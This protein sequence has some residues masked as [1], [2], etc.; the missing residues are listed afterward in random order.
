MSLSIDRNR[1]TPE[2]EFLRRLMLKLEDPTQQADQAV[3]QANIP[4]TSAKAENISGQTSILMNEN[5][6]MLNTLNML[7]TFLRETPDTVHVYNKSKHPVSGVLCNV[8]AKLV[9]IKS[10]ANTLAQEHKDR[11]ARIVAK[12]DA[13]RPQPR[14]IRVRPVKKRVVKVLSK[15]VKAYRIKRSESLMKADMLRPQAQPTCNQCTAL[16][17]FG[18][19]T[20]RC[21]NRTVCSTRCHLHHKLTLDDGMAVFTS[22]HDPKQRAY[23]APSTLPGAGTGVFAGMP[24]QCG[25]VITECD[26]DHAVSKAAF[27]DMVNE[28][29]MTCEYAFAMRKDKI[30]LGLGK[31]VLGRGIG[32]FCNSA[33]GALGKINNCKLVVRDERVLVVSIVD[34]IAPHSELLVSYNRPK[35]IGISVKQ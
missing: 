12:I 29:T 8:G 18:H 31:P 13:R 1:E 5:E 26:F 14:P 30:A 4:N 3:A 10:K 6:R 2:N 28:G 23:L 16:L 27:A 15:A 11:L 19:A 35:N 20:R 32:S 24:L 33:Y 22:E 9:Y 34:A 25:D 21:A 7:E 17:F